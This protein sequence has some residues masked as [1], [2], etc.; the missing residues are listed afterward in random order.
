[1]ITIRNWYAVRQHLK[2]A[3][4]ELSVEKQVALLQQVS[5][6]NAAGITG[7]VLVRGSSLWP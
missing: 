6:L 5:R 2:T 4:S 1:M 7:R 3:K